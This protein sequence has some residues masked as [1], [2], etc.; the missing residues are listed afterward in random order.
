M[1]LWGGESDTGCCSVSDVDDAR[2]VAQQLGIDHH[3]FNFGDDFDDPR[4]RAVRRRPRRRPHAEPVHRVQPP[5]QVRPPAAAGR[6]CSAS[7]PSPP[8]TTPGS[9]PAGPA[10]LGGWR[11][12]PT[13]PRTRAT[14][15]TCSTR[16]S[17]A[18]GPASR[19]ATSTKDEVRAVG[20]PRS[21]CAPRPSPTARTCAS[22]PR[23]PAARRFLERRVGA[24]ARR[25]WSTPA[26]RRGRH[27]RRRRAGHDRPAPRRHRRR[28]RRRAA[29]RGRR[30]R[31]QR[32]RHRRSAGRA[33]GPTRRAR[34]RWRGS[35]RR[36]PAGPRGGPGPV[37]C[38]R[39]A[40]PGDGRRVG[41]GRAGPSRSAGWHQGRPWCSTTRPTRYVLG[42]GVA[43]A[44]PG[45]G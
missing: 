35:T 37:Q 3:V 24:P 40:P 23:R 41:R 7:T 21:G 4:R 20:R 26:G 5:P 42:G 11:G 29:L 32:R 14:C 18:Q 9:S 34:R 10:R 2:R 12:A 1:K 45:T 33:A 30:R 31:A 15:C 27:G 17:L 38:P 44:G 43:M 8:A 13:G 6:R 28:G 36:S 25:S 19:S 16:P 22:S 39:P